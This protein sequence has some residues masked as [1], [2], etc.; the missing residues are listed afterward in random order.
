MRLSGVDQAFDRAPIKSGF[1]QIEQGRV[2]RLIEIAEMIDQRADLGRSDA[3]NSIEAD[4]VAHV[5]HD[6]SPS[7]A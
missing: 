5:V 7:R 2:P 4:P 6:L 1:F 3:V